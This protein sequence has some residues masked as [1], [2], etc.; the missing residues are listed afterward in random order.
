MPGTIEE[1]FSTG[2]IALIRDIELRSQI[3]ALGAWYDRNDEIVRQSMARIVPLRASITRKFQIVKFN[4]KSHIGSAEVEYDFDSLVE[5][6]VFI[7]TLSDLQTSSF[8][9]FQF[10]YGAMQRFQVLRDS[11]AGD[12]GI[13]IEGL[14]VLEPFP[15]L[16]FAI[17]ESQ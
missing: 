1:L 5:D 6:R 7:N 2:N 11:L 3:S 10:S 4:A 15:A 14:P 9:I 17:A 12:L 16:A 8:L 13:N